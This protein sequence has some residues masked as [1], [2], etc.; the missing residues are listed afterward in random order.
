ML[1]MLTGR[2]VTLPESDPFDREFGRM[3]RRF[4]NED[5]TDAARTGFYPANLWEDDD[6][7]YLEAEVP[8]FKREEIDITLDQGVLTIHAERRATSEE[9]AA[10]EQKSG[11]PLISERRF[12][13]YQRSFQLPGS[14]DAEQIKAHLEDGVLHLTMPKR[15]EVKPRRI[16][17]T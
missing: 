9:G 4:W 12:M 16:Q 1:P 14:V 17:I 10:R 2:N 3:M 13:R 5:G 15:A 7:V 6:N 8:G 11:S